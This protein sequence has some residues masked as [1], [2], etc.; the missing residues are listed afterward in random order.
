EA[1]VLADRAGAGQ[2]ELDAVVL[3]RVVRGGEHRPRGVE[4]ARGEVQEVG[5]A[6]P[7]VHDVQALA[8]DALGEGGGQLD[9]ARPHVAPDDDPVGPAAGGGDEAGEG[10]ADAVAELGVQLVRHRA[11]HVVGLEDHV[12]RV[13]VRHGPTNLVRA[14]APAPTA[15]GQPQAVGAPSGSTGGRSPSASYSPAA[16]QCR[17]RN[18]STTSWSASRMAETVER[19]GFATST[20]TSVSDRSNRSTRCSTSMS[21]AKPSTRVREKRKRATSERKPFSPLCVSRKL[22]SST[23]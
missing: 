23:A 9:A 14:A 17:M 15:R 12:E 22:P 2:A 7:H 4:A 19:G 8:L 18:M 3:G 5:R 13:E 6:Q 11:P 10:R 1:G 20:G 16:D 21:K